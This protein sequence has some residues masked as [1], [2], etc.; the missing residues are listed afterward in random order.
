MSKLST[1]PFSNLDL[2]P[3]RDDDHNPAPALKR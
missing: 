1:T 3:L 2:A